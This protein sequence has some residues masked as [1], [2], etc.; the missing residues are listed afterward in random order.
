MEV[1]TEEFKPSGFSLRC[2][3]PTA[4]YENDGLKADRQIDGSSALV[5]CQ[6]RFTTSVASQELAIQR[7]CGSP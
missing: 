4:E 2:L 3:L 7:P 5:T 6:G 1:S